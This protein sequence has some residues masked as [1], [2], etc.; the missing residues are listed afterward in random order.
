MNSV[1]FDNYGLNTFPM[2]DTV[3][4]A[5]PTS[6]SHEV[7]VRAMALR[8]LAQRCGSDMD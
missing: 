5:P 4:S 8:I 7:D 2:I 1:H 6:V 3:I